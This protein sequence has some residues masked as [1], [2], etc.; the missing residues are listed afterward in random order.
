MGFLGITNQEH[1]AEIDRLTTDFL[2]TTK[3]HERNI[4]ELRTLLDRKEN[5]IKQLTL[6]IKKLEA[7]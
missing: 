6:R 3:T 7:K 2:K 4:K 5:H 1:K